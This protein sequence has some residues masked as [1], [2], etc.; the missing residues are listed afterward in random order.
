MT[1]IRCADEDSWIGL[2]VEELRAI[3]RRAKAAGRPTVHLCIS[4]GS[5]PEPIYRAFAGLP[6]PGTALELWLGDERAVQPG[7]PARNDGMVSRAFASARWAPRL[8]PW[9]AGDYERGGDAAA[10]RDAADY[11]AELAS[12]LGSAPAFDLLI[13]GLGADGHTASLF[14]GSEALGERAAL[15]A[16]SRSP[17]PPALRMTLT[18]PAL[19]GAR[20]TLFA[21]GGAGKAGIVRALAAED[22]ALPASRAGGGDRA[23]VYL[24]A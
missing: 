18:Y 7:D 21:V 23:I 20:R 6:D 19:A 13:L 4:G 5:T 11:A 17:L 1:L 3:V 14:P 22:P 10:R 24:E 15:A 2:F 12:A 9:P 16:V 8:H